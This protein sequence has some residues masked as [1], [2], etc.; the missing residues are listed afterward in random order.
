MLTDAGTVE[1]E[2]M[3]VQSDGKLVTLDS[4]FDPVLFHRVRRFLPDG[5][6]DPTLPAAGTAWPSPWCPPAFGPASSRFSA[7]GRS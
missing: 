3:K 1:V 6:P 7:T 5:S 4:G 2:G